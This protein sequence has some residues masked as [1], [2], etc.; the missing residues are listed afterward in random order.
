MQYNY[1]NLNKQYFNKDSTWINY[2]FIHLA[3]KFLFH[4][5][6]TNFP[7]ADKTVFPVLAHSLDWRQKSDSLI[8]YIMVIMSSLLCNKKHDLYWNVIKTHIKF[9]SYMFS[10][11]YERGR[12]QYSFY[13]HLTMHAGKSANLLR[14][15]PFPSLYKHKV[16]CA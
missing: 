8:T 6:N 16:I 1:V 7:L 10:L 2:S 12:S 13:S 11:N 3:I 14:I 5:T 9:K 15:R 4:V